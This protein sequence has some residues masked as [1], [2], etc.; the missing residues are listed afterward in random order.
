MAL[1]FCGSGVAGFAGWCGVGGWGFRLGFRCAGIRNS[2]C[3]CG[4]LWKADASTP[5][6]P[7]VAR[8]G[9]V[10]PS[11]AAHRCVLAGALRFSNF[12][13]K[14]PQ[15]KAPA[16]RPSQPANPA[17]HAGVWALPCRPPA[18]LHEKEYYTAFLW[19]AIIKRKVCQRETLKNVASLCGV[20]SLNR[21]PP[22]NDHHN[23]KKSFALGSITL[24]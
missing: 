6:E 20:P 17:S 16:T 3:P 23:L 24:L 18:Y 15:P 11:V 14:S 22:H 7:S 12:L 10:L 1:L 13:P 8:P 19:V 2:K 5:D 21:C 4:R 9:F